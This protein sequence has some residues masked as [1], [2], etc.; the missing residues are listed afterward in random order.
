MKFR[1]FIESSFIDGEEDL[2]LTFPAEILEATGLREGDE[3]ELIS[4]P[5]G[6]LTVRQVTNK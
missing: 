5:D 3:L 1:G 6:S 2:F 4:N